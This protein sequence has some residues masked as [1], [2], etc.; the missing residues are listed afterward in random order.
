MVAARFPDADLSLRA[1]PDPDE[2]ALPAPR[3]TVPDALAEL[4]WTDEP[5]RARH[6]RGQSYTDVMTGLDGDFHTASDVVATPRDTGE[7]AAILEWCAD[8]GAACVPFGGGT[9]V[10]GGITPPVEDGPVVTLQTRAMPRVCELDHASRAARIQAGAVGPDLEAQLR[11]HGLTLRFFPQ[12]FELSTLGG[13]IATRAAGHYA[14]GPTHIDDLVEAVTAV[15]PRGLWSSRRL[16]AS[17]AGTSPDRMLLGSEGTLGVVTEAWVRLQHRPVHRAFAS[18]AFDSFGE[19]AQAV[20]WLAQ[21]GLAPANA[22]LLDATEAV[23]NGVGDGGSAVLLVGFESAYV[24]VAQTC[25]AAVAA[26]LE[27]GGRCPDGVTISE[28]T[29]QPDSAP[30]ASERPG[31]EATGQWREAFLRAPYLRDALARMG[32]ISETFETAVTWDRLDE[33]VGSVCQATQAALAEVCGDGLVTVRTTHAYPDGAAP[34][35]TIIAPGRRGAEA[36][37]WAEIKHAASEA[38]AAAGGTIT[39][40]HAVGREHRRWYERQRPEPFAA[41][42]SAAKRAVDPAG[43]LNPGV[44]LG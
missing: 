40:H 7:V 20:R 4:C 42:L 17:G 18:V 39:H 43:V 11:G 19:G 2:L 38:I 1:E 16:P 10:V 29:S 25:E 5:T 8:A 9:S 33:L 41:G 21:S 26:C 3:L 23:L 44:L 34:Y 28:D 27:L 22:R 37:Q 31:D 36:A 15:T 14:T 30:D 6:A 32:V 35:F 13:W 24:A 12:S